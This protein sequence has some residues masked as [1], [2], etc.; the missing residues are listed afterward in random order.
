MNES[1]TQENFNCRFI[2]NTQYELRSAAQ[3]YITNEI[4]IKNT[5]YFHLNLKKKTT[6]VV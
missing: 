6:N 1:C 3:T 5:F 2:A 4:N